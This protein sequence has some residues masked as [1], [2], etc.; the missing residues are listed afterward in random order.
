MWLVI[1]FI[2]LL[3]AIVVLLVIDDIK[4]R[5]LIINIADR[6]GGYEK[7]LE[8]LRAANENF[9]TELRHFDEIGAY[10]S[11]DNLGVFFQIIKD[12]MRLLDNFFEKEAE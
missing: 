1:I 5:K 7:T 10:E 11:D 9:L 3:L 4:Q 2:V 8:R 6:I 12:N